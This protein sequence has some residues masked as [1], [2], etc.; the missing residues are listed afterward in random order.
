M[1]RINIFIV[2]EP[3]V[4][5]LRKR[6]TYIGYIGWDLKRKIFLLQQSREE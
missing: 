1:Q 5:G 6:E 3:A 2:G 4:F